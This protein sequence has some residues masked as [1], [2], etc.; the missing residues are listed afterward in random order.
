MYIFYRVTC[1]YLFFTHY[2]C[3]VDEIEACNLVDS[4]C[5]YSVKHMFSVES[6]S[7]DL[8]QFDLEVNKLEILQQLKGSWL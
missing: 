7:T 8:A 2:S 4:S 1:N 3:D 6:M 5:I